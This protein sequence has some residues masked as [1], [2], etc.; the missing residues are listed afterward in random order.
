MN[1]KYAFICTIFA[2]IF[3]KQ[4]LRC[5]A[6][7]DQSKTKSVEKMPSIEETQTN[8][9]KTTDGDLENKEVRIKWQTSADRA[10][11]SSNADSSPGPKAHSEQN[12]PAEVITFLCL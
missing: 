12:L 6:T 2:I 8:K 9:R 7:T 4:M 5:S 10:E 11:S 3:D 1:A